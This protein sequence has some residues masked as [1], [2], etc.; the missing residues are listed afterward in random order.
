MP[1]YKSFSKGTQISIKIWKITETLGELKKGVSL[2]PR[3][4]KRLLKMKSEVHQKGFL[5][6]RHLLLEF[7]Y[8]DM[9]LQYDRN[10]KP[11]LEDKSFVSISHSHQFA[12]IA[13]S[14]NFIG[15]DIEK[16]KPKIKDIARKFIGYEKK[17]LHE[18][19]VNYENKLTAIWCIKESLYKLFG[20]P[21]KSFKE[22][23][24]VIPFEI[25]DL[26][27]VSW[28]Q[29]NQFKFKYFSNFIEFEGFTLAYTF[30]S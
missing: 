19:S 29:H 7:G 14:T 16:Q 28:I 9:D 13:V 8:K 18:K 27:T 6:V 25:S 24:F 3:S 12:V 17:Y 11:Y 20:I 5:S 10:G 22:H 15:V 1:L 21:G 4:L 2:E 30:P 26:S 23:F